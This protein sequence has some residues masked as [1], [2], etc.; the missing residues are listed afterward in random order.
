MRVLFSG[1]L[2]LKSREIEYIPAAPTSTNIALE[3]ILA[4]PKILSTRLNG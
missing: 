4:A 1:L 3:I 2:S